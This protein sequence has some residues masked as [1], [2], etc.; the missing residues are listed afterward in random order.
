MLFPRRQGRMA[1]GHH[2]SQANG[3]ASA[4]WWNRARRER[5]TPAKCPP[6]AAGCVDL[7]SPR[8]TTCIEFDPRVC[9]PRCELA[10][11]ATRRAF[12]RLGWLNA[13]SPS[14]VDP[15]AQRVA[16]RCRGLALRGADTEFETPTGGERKISPTGFEPETFGSGGRRSIQLSYGDLK[17][18]RIVVQTCVP[19]LCSSVGGVNTPAVQK[20]GHLP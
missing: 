7:A 10:A 14:G 9:W 15:V 11:D 19:S 1:A 3:P 17:L 16:L 12:I 18:E 13:V 6:S 2:E 20:D 8:S 5:L 4:G